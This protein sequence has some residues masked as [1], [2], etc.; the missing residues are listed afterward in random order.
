MSKGISELCGFGHLL[1]LHICDNVG[2][3]LVGN[4]YAR[5]EWE[6]EA[7]VAV[8]N[9]NERWYGGTLSPPVLLSLTCREAE[10]DDEADD[11]DRLDGC[12]FGARQASHSLQNSHL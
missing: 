2:D 6:A 12:V 11:D 7:A 4:V 8:A 5:F 10:R 3:H 1:E 9:L